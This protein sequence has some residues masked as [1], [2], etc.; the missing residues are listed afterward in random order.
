MPRPTAVDRGVPDAGLPAPEECVGYE[1][2]DPLGQKV[3]N[4]EKVFVNGEGEPEYVL[5]QIRRFG[6]RSVLLPV[7]TVAVDGELRTL[8]LG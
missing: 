4:V 3:G 7:Q 8:T 2:L 5:V 1:V 6:R